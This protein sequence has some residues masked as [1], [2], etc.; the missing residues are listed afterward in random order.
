MAFPYRR[1]LTY[2]HFGL[3]P[4]IPGFKVTLWVCYTGFEIIVRHPSAVIIPIV[5]PEHDQTPSVEV[6][7][8]VNSYW[9]A[10]EISKEVILLSRSTSIPPE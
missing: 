2:L 8:P 10:S 3:F 5:C 4:T 9:F 7:N 6:V 1:V